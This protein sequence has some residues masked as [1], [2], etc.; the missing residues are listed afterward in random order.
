VSRPAAVVQLGS[1]LRR[2]LVVAH[3]EHADA[4]LKAWV[5]LAE[6]LDEVPGKAVVVVDE[7]NH[8]RE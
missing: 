6:A 4:G 3:D 7:Q 1:L 8:A 5:K 2:D